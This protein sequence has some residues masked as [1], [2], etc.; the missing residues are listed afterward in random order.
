LFVRTRRSV[1]LTSEGELLLEK[2]QQVIRAAGDLAATARRLTDGELGRLRI[3][4]TPSA[5]HHVL[6]AL[7][8]ALGVSRFTI[9]GQPF[10]R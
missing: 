4:F 6:P 8:Q 1:R 10:E 3:G 7:M 5:P 9:E 2:A